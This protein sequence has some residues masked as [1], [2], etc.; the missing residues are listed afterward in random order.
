MQNKYLCVHEVPSWN[1]QL[2]Y[3]TG[4]LKPV[5]RRANLTLSS[6]VDQ[7]T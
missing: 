6:D 1:G 4:G 5:S 2:K 3:L 7:D